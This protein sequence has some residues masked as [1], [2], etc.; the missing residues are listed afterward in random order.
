MRL[1]SEPFVSD[2][3]SAVFDGLI[4][5]DGRTVTE[6]NDRAGRIFG[7]DSGESMIGLPYQALLAPGGRRATERRV[8]AQTEGRYSTLC[9]RHDGTEFAADVNVKEIGRKGARIRLVALRYSA[10]DGHSVDDAFIQ[11]S[12]AFDQTVVAL[13]T[14]I[15]QRDSFTAG[16]QTR[17]SLLGTQIAESLGMSEREIATIRTAGNIH[18]IGKV[19]VPA[20]I[21]MKPGS[22][23]KQE[24]ELIKNHP[25]SGYAIV[26]SIDFDGP[27]R[28]IIRQHHERIDGSGYP[29]GINDPVP[30]AR[31]IAV[32]DVYDAMTSSRPYRAG[33]S[34][35]DTIHHMKE[36]ESGLDPLALDKLTSLVLR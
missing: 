14:T 1:F 10:D 6:A 18:D 29:L 32:A 26:K 9:R 27:V 3:V 7:Y 28:D 25:E 11:R 33:M 24:Y 2:L 8:N 30:S 36:K 15:E 31:I 5:H 17:V 16:H 34:P 35:D 21:L 19:A 22:L 12:L 20:E 13:A 4:V 23:S